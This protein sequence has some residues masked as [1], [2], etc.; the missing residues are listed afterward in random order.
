MLG[1]Q[2]QNWFSHLRSEFFAI[3]CVTT[4]NPKQDDYSF[5]LL[6]LGYCPPPGTVDNRSYIQGCVHSNSNLYPTVAGRRQYAS[7]LQPSTN[8][9]DQAA[10]RWFG[11]EGKLDG[12]SFASLATSYLY[13]ANTSDKVGFLFSCACYT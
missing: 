5:K 1:L 7:K 9:F 2:P 11:T 6:Q 8:G 13:S 4:T 3:I 12:T 10:R